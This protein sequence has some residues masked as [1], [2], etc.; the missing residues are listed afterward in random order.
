MSVEEQLILILENEDTLFLQYL[1]HPDN[2]ILCLNISQFVET[3]NIFLND[4]RIFIDREVRV[5]G[6]YLFFQAYTSS[7]LDRNVRIYSFN[8]SDVVSELAKCFEV[9]CYEPILV[10]IDSVINE[11]QKND[12]RIDVDL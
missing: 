4:S 2:K 12:L 3:Y 7:I 6:Q 8:T 9:N 10:V 5:D 1:K 11:S